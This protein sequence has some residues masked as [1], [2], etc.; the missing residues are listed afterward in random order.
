MFTYLGLLILGRVT[1]IAGRAN[2]YGPITVPP[3]IRDG[4]PHRGQCP[5]P[6][7]YNAWVLQ[8]P[9]EFMWARVV[10]NSLLFIILIQED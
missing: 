8:H 2:Y 9:T 7:T 1:A 10:K 5:L 6:L 4:P 3:D